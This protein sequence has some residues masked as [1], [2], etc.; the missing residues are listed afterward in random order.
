[1]LFG[2]GNKKG[3]KLDGFT[4]VIVNIEETS[5]NDLWI[6][7]ENDHVKASIL[8]RFY[9]NPKTP[10][11]LPRPFGVLYSENRKSYEESV[12]LQIDSI[13]E[14]NGNGNLDSLL[15]GKNTWEIA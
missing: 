13:I 8:A 12:Q 9:D 6:H 4:P 7:D 5:L 1:L 3:I 2:H 10:G 11:H 15:R 14:K